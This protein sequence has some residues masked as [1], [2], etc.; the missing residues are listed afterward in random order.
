MARAWVWCP[1]FDRDRPIQECDPSTWSTFYGWT[2][3]AAI[4]ALV[5]HL[6]L[7]HPDAL[8]AIRMID[9]LPATLIHARDVSVVEGR[10]TEGR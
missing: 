3:A 8:Q 10:P 9:E 7:Y 6:R 1:F 2:D 5:E 4:V